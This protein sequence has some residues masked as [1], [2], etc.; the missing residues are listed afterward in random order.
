MPLTLQNQLSLQSKYFQQAMMFIHLLAV[1]PGGP[2][3][4]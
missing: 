3:R 1:N 4:Q 2:K